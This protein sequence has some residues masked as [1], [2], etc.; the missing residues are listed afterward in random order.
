MDERRRGWPSG[1]T[2]PSDW[3]ETPT[4]TALLPDRYTPEDPI[5]LEKPP[6]ASFQFFVILTAILVTAAALFVLAG[7]MR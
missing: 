3:D 2:P 1:V 7:L 5:V 4:R 6:S